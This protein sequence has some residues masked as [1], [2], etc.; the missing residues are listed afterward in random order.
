MNASKN[1]FIASGPG[2]LIPA[3]FLAWLVMMAA[4][5]S[6]GLIVESR[7]GH[8]GSE[9]VIAEYVAAFMISMPLPFAFVIAIVYTPVA[10]GVRAVTSV[11]ASPMV[12]GAACGVA[13]P[14]AGLIL[15]VVGSLLWGRPTLG[16][17]YIKHGWPLLAIALGGLAF[18]LTFGW[19]ERRATGPSARALVERGWE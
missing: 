10:L 5:L 8:L 3:A 11:T 16:G 7:L 14:L 17:G 15:F 9:T 6:L 19:I 13:A 1:G 4:G 2:I 18:G 12:F